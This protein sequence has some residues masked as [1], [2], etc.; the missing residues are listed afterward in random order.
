MTHSKFLRIYSGII[1]LFFGLSSSVSAQARKSELTNDASV[2][3]PSVSFDDKGELVLTSSPTSSL[4]DFDF[5]TGKWKMYHSRLNKRLEN[6]KEWTEFV[7]YD[8]N[9]KILSGNANMDTYRT[10]EMPGMNGKLFEGL[11][12]RLFDPETKLWSLYWVA[13][14]TGKLDP[15]VVGS[16]SNNIG[17]FF[18]KDVYHGK[19]IIVVFRWDARDKN[20]PIWSQAFSADKGKT[21]EWNWFNVSERV[22]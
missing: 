20:R 4:N 19:D 18:C 1:M 8:E 6:C 9:E 22:K 17:H 21:W 3:I 7:S 10:T 12:I 16:F 15:P 14:N 2:P 5:L 11:T 13:S